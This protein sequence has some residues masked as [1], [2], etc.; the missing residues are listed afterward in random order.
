MIV[1]RI[2]AI[3]VSVI[4]ASGIL[5]AFFSCERYVLPEVEI[6]PDTLHFAAGVDSLPMFLHTNVIVNTEAEDNAT[7]LETWPQGFDEDSDL[8]V[9]V[10]PLSGSE[11]RTGVI[12]FKSE[13]L[14][15]KL[16]VIQEPLPSEND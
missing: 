10:D 14:Q 6:Y 3:S 2:A 11:S 8:F 15:R 7:W 1:R 5:G 9:Y 13:A 16:V 4:I 12:L